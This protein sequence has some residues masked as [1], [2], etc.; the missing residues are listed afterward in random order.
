MSSIACYYCGHILRIKE[1][2]LVCSNV[3]C[4][5]FGEQQLMYKDITTTSDTHL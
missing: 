4:K 5:L 2:K 3:L 1:A